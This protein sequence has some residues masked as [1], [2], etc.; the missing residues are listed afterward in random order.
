MGISIC[1]AILATVPTPTPSKLPPVS[2]LGVLI[3][4]VYYLQTLS[5][6]NKAGH[7]HGSTVHS[8]SSLLF[9]Q[10]GKMNHKMFGS[11][12]AQETFFFHR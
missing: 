5:P 6:Q 8:S 4:V 7:S 1:V 9:I 2:G 12:R 10:M 11:I 3:L